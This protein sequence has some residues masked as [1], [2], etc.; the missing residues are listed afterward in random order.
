[1][2]PITLKAI[3]EIKF[4]NKEC[5]EGC[6]IKTNDIRKLSARLYQTIKAKSIQSM[7]PLCE[8]LLEQRD[9]ALGVI[10]YDWAYRIKKHYSIE[11]FPIFEAWLIKYVRGWGDCDDFCTHAFGE[12]LCQYPELIESIIPWTHREEFWLR[13]AAAVILIPA[14]RKDKL[15]KAIP[16]QISDLL[17]M[18]EH[19]LVLKGYGWMLKVF[20]LKEPGMV[21]NYLESHTDDMPRVAFRYALEKLDKQLRTEL[22]QK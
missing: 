15:N 2:Q 18:D 10:A 1:M 19:D 13:R 4:L 17:L 3:Q 20:S 5:S 11:T 6:H 12:L 9:W 14:I 22:M 8:E 7:L 16:F 21:Y